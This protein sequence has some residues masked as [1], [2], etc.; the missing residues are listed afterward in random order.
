MVVAGPR[1]H[2]ALEYAPA[3]RTRRDALPEHT[4]YADTGCDWHPTCLTCPFV[5]CRYDE[6]TGAVKRH[7]GRQRDR[8]IVDLQRRGKTINVIAARFGVSRRTVFRVLARARTSA[9][10]QRLPAG[11][12]GLSGWSPADGQRISG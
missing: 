8:R 1:G 11:G 10:G 2:R 9:D 3:R 5:R 7:A 12:R 4:Q 6:D